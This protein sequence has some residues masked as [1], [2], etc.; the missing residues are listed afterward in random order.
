MDSS[1][2]DIEYI[3]SEHFVKEIM[4]EQERIDNF[5]AMEQ[6]QTM[7]ITKPVRFT[8][9]I[10]LELNPDKTISRIRRGIIGVIKEELDDAAN[11]YY[12]KKIGKSDEKKSDS[13]LTTE[14]LEDFSRKFPLLGEKLKKIL[15]I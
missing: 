2:F 12:C 4:D 15:E 13:H 8:L 7:N 5:C 3:S 9:D 6:I 1:F 10:P 14:E 11:D